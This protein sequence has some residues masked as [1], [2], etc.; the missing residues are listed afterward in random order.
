MSLGDSTLDSINTIHSPVTI[1]GKVQG[2]TTSMLV[3][4][5]S[6]LSLVRE[7]LWKIQQSIHSLITANGSKLE[8]I[9]K[10]TATI[11]VGGMSIT[12]P[13][14]IT[15]GLS[16][17]CILGA[18]FLMK[19]NGSVNLANMTL[20]INGKSVSHKVNPT[21][22][23]VRQVTIQNTTTIPGQHELQIPVY[24]D[25]YMQPY[26]FEALSLLTERHGLLVAQNN[27]RQ[28]V[29]HILNPLTCYCPQS[30]ESWTFQ[31]L[32]EE[33]VIST[34]YSNSTCSDN[35]NHPVHTENTIISEL[36]QKAEGLSVEHVH[37]N[38]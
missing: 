2:Y 37:K 4:T 18:D 23:T 27:G 3:D 6:A 10:T 7:D 25:N 31:P 34:V 13:V 20:N 29:V 33:D 32:Q 30:C 15:K 35:L 22:W 24:A 9:S 38:S 16:Q 1:D 11:T 14:I 12:M 28:A 5:G 26:I 19:N 17:P 36:L 21:A 8:V